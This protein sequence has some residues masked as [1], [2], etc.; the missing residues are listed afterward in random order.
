LSSEREA[1]LVRTI[2]VL[3]GVIVVAILLI[4]SLSKCSGSPKE[5][6]RGPVKEQLKMA[7][8]PPAPY[9]D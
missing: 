9:V 6:K 2:L 5:M 1:L 8:E 3:A 4:S 7:V